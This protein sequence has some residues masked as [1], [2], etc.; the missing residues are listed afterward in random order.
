MPQHAVHAL[1]Q[2]APAVAPGIAL[3]ID[4]S[5]QRLLRLHQL[6][7]QCQH[8]LG[9]AAALV[10]RRRRGAGLAPALEHVLSPG[11]HDR[12]VDVGKHLGFHRQHRTARLRTQLACE[13][14]QVALHHVASHRGNQDHAARLP[15]GN[16]A[17]RQRHQ[18]VLA[19]GHHVGLAQIAGIDIVRGQVAPPCEIAV[20]VRAALRPVENNRR[21]LD[22]GK[23][24]QIARHL[25]VHALHVVHRGH[26]NA[27]QH[28]VALVFVEMIQRID[29]PFCLSASN[30]VHPTECAWS[31]SPRSD[32]Y[33]RHKHPL[34][35]RKQNRIP[36][37][38]MLPN[39]SDDR[40]Y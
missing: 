24:R 12:L 22:L 9:E 13:T 11:A 38:T 30:G 2:R 4:R 19:A 16:D 39:A 34:S 7:G 1:Q 31:E 8:R 18:F 5:G 32:K 21:V 14:R 25:A 23:R 10:I 29:L 36:F 27:H 33:S 40:R 6:L 28:P 37:E 20:V 17:P 15:F 3:H 26:M 35:G